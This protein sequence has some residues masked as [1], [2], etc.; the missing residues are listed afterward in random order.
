MF[1][2]MTYDA[3]TDRLFGTL[4]FENSENPAE[5]YSEIYTVDTKTFETTQV[6][7]VN[8]LLFTLSAD[9]GN[10]YGVARNMSLDYKDNK[11]AYLI[12][13]PIS[14]IHNK[15]CTVEEI[16]KEEGLGTSINFAQ[17]MEFDKTNHKL[18]WLAVDGNGNSSLAEIDYAAG[19]IKEKKAVPNLQMLAMSIPYQAVKDG[20]PSYPTQFSVE[21]AANGE[22]KAILSWKNPAVNYQNKPLASLTE[23]KIFRDDQ[24]VHTMPTTEI[25]AQKTLEDNGITESRYYTYKI[26]PVNNEGE[27]VSNDA[28]VFV[29]RDVP[30]KVESLVLTA[31]ESTGSLSWKAPSKGKYEGWF[32]VSSLKYKVVRMP[33]NKEI[34]KDLTETKC[35]DVVEKTAG[36]YYVVTAYNVDGEGAPAESNVVSFGPGYNIPYTT[37]LQTQNEFNEWS[38]IDANND[39]TTWKYDANTNITEYEYC[40]NSANDYLVSPK[41]HFEAG[42]Q[43][44]LRYTYYTI[45]WVEEGTH[46]PVMEKMKVYYGQ[47]PTKE[48]LSH[49]IKDLGE[50]HTASG[51]YLYGKDFFTT[52]SGVGHI[53]FHACSDPDRS[54]IYLKDVSLREYSD[55][56]LSIT[57]LNGNTTAN[58]KSKQTFVVEVSNEGS[59]AVN[60][61]KVQLFNTKTNEVLGETQGT[62]AIAKDGKL[63]VRIDWTPTTEGKINVSAKVILE[64]DTYL[65]DN[66]WNKPIEVLVAPASDEQWLTVNKNHGLEKDLTGWI[67]PFSLINNYSQIQVIYLDRE[68]QKPNIELRGIQFH[69]NGGE[70]LAS[71]TTPVKISIMNTT[72]DYFKIDDDATVHMMAGDWQTVYE[73]DIT[74][75]GNEKNTS[76]IIPFTKKYDYKGGNIVVKYERLMTDYTQK[77]KDGYTPAWHYC[78]IFDEGEPYMNR[79]AVYRNNFSNVVDSTLVGSSY[80]TPFTMFSYYDPNS[81]LE[82]LISLDPDGFRVYQTGDVLNLTKTFDEVQLISLSGSFVRSAH[83]VNSISVADLKGVYLLKLNSNGKMRTMKVAIK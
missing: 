1:N 32:D 45:N 12:K 28:N 34:K 80:W 16:N 79:T 58:L 25:G 68:M 59:A 39:G 60:N 55:K 37:S 26:I 38:K 74:V 21:A 35:E 49:L 82:G 43:Y 8:H 64:G 42:K 53:A 30:G 19:K 77:A 5:S 22:K 41:I 3:Q 62:E 36:Y 67:M 13:I 70:N 65:P 69:Y 57:N 72:R 2:D 83:Q 18:W 29:D 71:Y 9:N 20:A 48:G 11:A 75:A 66:E 14:S 7:K 78:E 81:G 52:Q 6:A 47:Q 4:Y 51:V 46:K 17:S 73:G 40:L 33:D 63:N 10:L 50:F 54:I 23:I 15:T 27:G 44:L 76:L 56:D 31:T 61:Y 24:L